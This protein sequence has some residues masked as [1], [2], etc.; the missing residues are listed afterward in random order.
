MANRAQADER[1]DELLTND[2]TN[3]VATDL[4]ND[5][6]ELCNFPGILNLAS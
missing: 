6:P 1:P 4:T 5:G 2:V 3:D